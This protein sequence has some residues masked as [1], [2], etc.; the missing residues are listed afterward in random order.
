VSREPNDFQDLFRKAFEQKSGN[1]RPAGEKTVIDVPKLPSFWRNRWFWIF[2]LG[3]ILIL[4]FRW[5]VTT[6]TDWLWFTAQDYASVWMTQWASRMLIFAVAFV[7]AVGLMVLNWA[8]ARK[9]GR[10]LESARTIKLLSIPGLPLLAMVAAIFIGFVF[11]STASTQWQTF[12]LYGNRVAYGLADPLF[13]KDLSFYLF[14]LPIFRFIQGWLLA[15]LIVTVIGTVGVYLA[16]TWQQALRRQFGE[17]APVR[18]HVAILAVFIFALW[19]LGHLLGVYDLLHST[20]G[21]VYGAS[22]TDIKASLPALYIQAALMGLLSLVSLV[23]IFRLQTRL[24]AVTAGA[25]LLVSIAVGGIYGAGLQRYVVEPNEL[26]LESTYIKNNIEFTQLG[27]GLNDIDVRKFGTV[28]ELEYEDLQNNQST[29]KNVRLWDYRPL[30]QTYAQLQELRPYY[31]FS[32]VDIDRYEIDGETRQVMLAARELNKD[33][34]PSPSWVNTRLEFTHGYGLVMSPVDEVS[35]EGRPEFFIRDLPPVSTVDIQVDRPEIYYGELM[36]DIVLVGSNLEEFDYPLGTENAYSTYSG[37]GGVELGGF[38]RRLA[39]AIRFG[40]SNLLL[41]QYVDSETRIMMYR[42]VTERIS[43]TTPFLHLDHDPYLVVA[44]GRLVWMVD[45]Y[46]LSDEFPYST[47][48]SEGFNYIRNSAKITVDAYDGKITYYMSDTEDPL[49]QAYDGIFP[50]LF[51]PLDQMPASLL[52]HIRYPEQLFL[53]QT[54]QYLKYHMTEE[55]VF[56]NQEDLWQI[57]MEI[58][59]SIQQPLEPY[60]VLL[61]LPGEEESEYLLIQPYTPSGKNNM[62]AWLAARNDPPHYG[63]L[64]VYELPKQELVFGPIQIEG[65]IDQDP[66]ISQQISLWNQRGSRVI[67]GN[68]IVIPMNSSFLY[69][70]PLYLL[71]DTSALPELQRVIVASG[72]RVAMRETL[73][74]A[75]LAL[76][77]TGPAAID[78]DVESPDQP[79]E[80]I[81]GFETVIELVESANAHFEAAEQAQRDGDWATYGTEL[82]ALQADL[83]KLQELSGQP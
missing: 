10:E 66:Q 40:E 1:D 72:D 45:A 67:R 27:F 58:F 25:W 52:S 8:L 11:A 6:Y 65:R 80:A 48:V 75:L 14:E 59:D 16:A 64:V 56:Y 71:S 32:S 4:S 13:D 62:I 24:A 79:I 50:G 69:V 76:L 19:G 38:L 18:R 82:A 29:L 51:K 63:E 47:P 41:S 22:Y 53:F 73:D 23:S 30:Q 44:D 34:L 57:P 36:D 21:V 43:R 17:I 70:E 83:V 68:L 7:I 61:T 46:T 5:M 35:P 54:R 28:S 55:Q 60:Y 42:T 9:A 78:P 49:I 31:K 81:P 15:L 26:A 37:E 39:F 20:R 3:S 77:G 33:N 74:E 2:L 12:L